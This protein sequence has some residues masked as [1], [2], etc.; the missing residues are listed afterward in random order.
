MKI[1]NLYAGIGGNRKL[2]VGHEVTAVEPEVGLHILN[3]AMGFGKTNELVANASLFG[4]LA[5]DDKEEG[6]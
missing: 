5:R 1:L 2:W 3:Q 6:K 4:E